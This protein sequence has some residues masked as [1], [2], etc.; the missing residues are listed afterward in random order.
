VDLI[1]IN[2]VIS[3]LCEWGVPYITLHTSGMES[4]CEY[5]NLNLFWQESVCWGGARRSCKKTTRK[6]CYN[7]KN[8]RA[9]N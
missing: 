9:S 6:L 3:V 4:R 8:A 1:L 7:G 5:W 2:E